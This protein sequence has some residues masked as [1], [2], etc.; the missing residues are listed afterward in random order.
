MSDK[1]QVVNEYDGFGNLIKTTDAYNNVTEYTYDNYNNL[2]TMTD[3]YGR[4]TAYEYDYDD[5]GNV[6]RRTASRGRP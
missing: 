2:V 1:V 5:F 4:V 6:I 3:R